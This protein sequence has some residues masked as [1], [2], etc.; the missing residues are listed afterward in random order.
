MNFSIFMIENRFLKLF[1]QQFEN[2]ELFKWKFISNVASSCMYSALWP[3]TCILFSKYF[4]K[5]FK[6]I[7]SMSQ[8]SQMKIRILKIDSNFKK[9]ISLLGGFGQVESIGII[10]FAQ[11]EAKFFA[12]F[13]EPF[14]FCAELK[15]KLWSNIKTKI[16]FLICVHVEYLSE[17]KSKM[18]IYSFPKLGTYNEKQLRIIFHSLS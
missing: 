10:H 9:F 5:L 6:N 3:S 7:M 2:F 8:T 12:L 17:P 1:G 13:F 18:K 11:L 16:L 15:Q 4:K 14:A